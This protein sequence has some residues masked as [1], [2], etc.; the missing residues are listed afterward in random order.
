[1]EM[2]PSLLSTLFELFSSIRHPDLASYSGE[3][4]GL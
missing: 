2:I 3:F 4:M 1:M